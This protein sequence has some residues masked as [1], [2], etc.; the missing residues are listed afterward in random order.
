MLDPER[1]EKNVLVLNFSIFH[2][3]SL[4]VKKAI[5]STEIFYKCRDYLKNKKSSC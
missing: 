1:N 2:V 3:V 4:S 5:F